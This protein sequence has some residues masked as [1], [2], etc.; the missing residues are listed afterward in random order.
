MIG[1]IHKLLI[2]SF[3]AYSKVELYDLTICVVV[4][5]KNVKIHRDLAQ[6][7]TSLKIELVRAIFITRVYNVFHFLELL[8]FEL[9]CPPPTQTLASTLQLRFTLITIIG[10][11]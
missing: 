2:I 3:L 6:T 10:L 11:Y 7:P 8:H 4:N 9:L 1:D 5:G